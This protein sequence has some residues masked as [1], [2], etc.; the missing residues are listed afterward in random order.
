MWIEPLPA[1]QAS[2]P[3]QEIYDEV[4]RTYGAALDPVA[5]LAH[6][7]EALRAYVTFEREIQKTHLRAIT[8]RSS[9]TSARP[10]SSPHYPEARRALRCLRIGS[11]SRCLTVTINPETNVSAAPDKMAS[12]TPNRSASIP[13]SSAPTA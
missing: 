13:A 2:Q 9:T 5:V 10:S 11:V 4:R 6:N 1:N 3:V 8:Y 12:P 7:T